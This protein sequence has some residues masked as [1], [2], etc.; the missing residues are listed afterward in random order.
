VAGRPRGRGGALH[1][2]GGRRRPSSGAPRSS[3]APSSAR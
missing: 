2:R 3:L 1:G